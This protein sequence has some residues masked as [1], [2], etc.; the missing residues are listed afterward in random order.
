MLN[1]SK[2]NK[3]LFYNLVKPYLYGL[4]FSILCTI[5]P[6]II[7]KN[8]FFSRKI[9]IL[10]IIFF[11]TIQIIIQFKYFL[12]VKNYLK[13]SWSN[14]SLF[15]AVFLSAIILIGSFWIMIHLHHDNYLSN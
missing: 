1:N 2:N 14:I 13:D 5:V 7:L 12:K 11:L 10:I 6:F 8:N 9:S 4:L 15:F 3:K